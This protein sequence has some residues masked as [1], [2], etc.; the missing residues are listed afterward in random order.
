MTKYFYISYRIL[1]EILTR[2]SR[3]QLLNHNCLNGHLASVPLSRILKKF[4]FTV[5]YWFF[6]SQYWQYAQQCLKYNYRNVLLIITSTTTRLNTE[7]AIAASFCHHKLRFFLRN[8]TLINSWWQDPPSPYFS[9]HPLKGH[10]G[11]STPPTSRQRHDTA[12]SAYHFNPSS[13][14]H[15][16]LRMREETEEIICVQS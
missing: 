7:E 2:Q 11:I 3:V 8:C 4:I 15:G 13:S 9:Y 10:A 12:G 16:Y 14:N 1:A 6:N 5:R